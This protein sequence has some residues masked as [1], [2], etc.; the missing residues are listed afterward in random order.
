MS[1]QRFSTRILTAA[2]LGSVLT[3]APSAMAGSCPGGSCGGPSPVEQAIAKVDAAKS[4]VSN[5]GLDSAYE[6][7]ETVHEEA[8]KLGVENTSK[9]NDGIKDLVKT[10]QQRA[11]GELLAALKDYEEGRYD[12][13]I[14]AYERIAKLT[15][16]SAAKK[17]QAELDIE[18]DRVKWR[19]YY[20]T[21]KQQVSA[22][23]HVEARETLRE[24]KSLSRR[25]G[26]TN[27]LR[28]LT[29]ELA[30][31]LQPRVDAAAD[32]VERG[33]YDAAYT[34]L[35][36]ISRLSEVR[37]TAIAARKVISQNSMKPGMRQA[38]A[39][40]EGQQ[41][42]TEV[43]GWISDIAHPSPK[44]LSLYR[45]T[46]DQIATSYGNT[47]AGKEAKRLLDEKSTQQ[48]RY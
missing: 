2:L 37:T 8:S 4:T 18:P 20:T 12:T 21:A 19:E 3:F 6:T 1:T 13:A 17:A 39:E 47:Q 33:Q 34:T 5:A 45:T 40:Y 28:E 38:K 9:V 35:I 14:A 41:R 22:S 31:S 16:L 23:K 25:T 29:D 44:E 10:L 42:L 32:A 43:Q 27:D 24:L 48:A 7:I 26:Y 15:G 36:E 46:L 30:K 11:Q